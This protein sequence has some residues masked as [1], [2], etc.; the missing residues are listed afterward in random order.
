MH[1]IYILFILLSIQQT[2]VNSQGRGY[3]WVFGD[4]AGI[5]FTGGQPS[6]FIT[7]I[8]SVEPS[9]SISDEQGNLLFY[10]GN[11]EG[12]MGNPN[13]YITKVWDKNSNLM[14]NGDSLQSTGTT[15]Q[16]CIILTNPADSSEFYIFNLGYDINSNLH[17][18]F[19]SNINMS[20]NG[21]YGDVFQKNTL[22]CDSPLTEKMCA[23]K[24]G[25][26]RDWWLV[27][28][29]FGTNDFYK[30]LITTSNVLGP[31][32]QSIGDFI[33]IRDEGQMIFNQQG[34]KLAFA[35]SSGQLNIFDFDRCTG[36]LSN[37]L[38]LS[39]LPY[40]CCIPKFYGCSFSGNSSVFYAS[41]LDSLFQFDLNATNVKA[42]RVLIGALGT[43]SVGGTIIIGQHLIGPN[44]RIYI[45]L[46]D[47]MGNNCD[48]LTK[49]LSVINDPDQIGSACNF[50]PYNIPL[51]NCSRI[52]GGL[53]NMPNYN[54]RN[55]IGSSCD[56]I[57]VIAETNYSNDTFEV[58]PNPALSTINITYSLLEND[59]I[60]EF[61]Q[62][63]GK[64]ILQSKI[65]KGLL[66]KNIDISNLIPGVY[67]LVVKNKNGIIG[68]RRIVII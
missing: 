45:A 23:V 27:T 21:G 59:A 48:S 62:T 5:S 20:L 35:N 43:T 37:P 8:N 24:H 25:N 64:L 6:S 68:K 38:L 44:G 42:S 63:D 2:T 36:L 4:S 31:F 60:V 53:P 19:Y 66:Q 61:F 57:T 1:K 52:L 51:A 56:T 29:L 32:I 41:S 12:F 67:G 55:L 11:T 9:A 47:Q 39:D 18:L 7:V 40:I 22:V 49:H 65:S 54:L 26:G 30:Y 34:S 16:G 58:H 50:L 46:T 28:H 3:N 10:N 13:F 14:P 33:D 17:H 15:T